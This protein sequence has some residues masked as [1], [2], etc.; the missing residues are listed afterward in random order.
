MLVI[1][2][3][4]PTVVYRPQTL[5]LHTWWYPQLSSFSLMLSRHLTIRIHLPT[6]NT[7]YVSIER[8]VL[9]SIIRADLPL[10]PTLV[11]H[12]GDY[13]RKPDWFVSP[14]NLLF[15]REPVKTWDKKMAR[16][17]F[18]CNRL[19]RVYVRN[20][21]STPYWKI[22]IF[23]TLELFAIFPRWQVTCNQYQWQNR[24]AAYYW[25]L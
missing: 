3:F 8:R 4:T 14:E 23:L 10:F 1:R 17:P 2:D 6:C 11:T 24:P 7:V 9:T 22:R 20:A 13:F 16:I 18:I 21:A 15:H 12:M 19:S 5:P 25:R